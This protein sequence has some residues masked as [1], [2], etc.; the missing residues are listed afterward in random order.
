MNI[1]TDSK[2]KEDDGILVK[3]GDSYATGIDIIDKQH[4][5][6]I[7]LTNELYRNCLSG[8][9][10]NKFKDTLS[11]MVTYVRFH[12]SAE[13]E[14]L[15]RIKYPQYADH[16][17]QHDSLVM[18]VLDAAKQFNEGKKYVPNQFVRSLKD[19]IFGHIAYADKVYSAY[20]LDQKKK[21]LLTDQQIN[22]TQK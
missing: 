4:I 20:I 14:L 22:G 16:K 1:K 3:W 12:F 17:K 2:I 19:W 9:I 18:N 6:L 15:A 8:D 5:E 7:N 11:R 13:L 10:E 21:G